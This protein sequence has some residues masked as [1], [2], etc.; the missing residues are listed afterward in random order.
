MNFIVLSILYIIYFFVTFTLGNDRKIKC[1]QS[2]NPHSTH[3]PILKECPIEDDSC[4]VIYRK[5]DVLPRY[6]C[7]SKFENVSPQ[8]M[9][10]K[11]AKT[12]NTAT[13]FTSHSNGYIHKV[14]IHRVI[15]LP[16][17][18]VLDRADIDKFC[19][20]QSNECNY[21]NEQIEN[22]FLRIDSNND[23]EHLH[24]QAPNYYIRNNANIKSLSFTSYFFIFFIIPAILLTIV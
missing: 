7:L 22:Y 24:I 16:I 18:Y 12:P 23:D 6:N 5:G 1:L 15:D 10:I 13:C 21:D 11:C 4:I 2:Y 9:G 17:S 8:F 20:C 19:C 14:F 3:P